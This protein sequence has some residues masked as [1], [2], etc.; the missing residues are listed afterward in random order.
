MVKTILGRTISLTRCAWI[1]VSARQYLVPC[2]LCQRPK[3]SSLLHLSCCRHLSKKPEDKRFSILSNNMNINDKFRMATHFLFEGWVLWEDIQ[4]KV[5]SWNSKACLCFSLF[6]SVLPEVLCLS[7]YSALPVFAFCLI[8][9][10]AFPQMNWFPT[11][12]LWGTNQA[13][14]ESSC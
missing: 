4:G 13:A 7:G 10:C 5:T 14:Y 8:E 9:N 12:F 3:L 1:W 2:H 11:S 6:P